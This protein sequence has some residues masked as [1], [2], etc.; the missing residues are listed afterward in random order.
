MVKETVKNYPNVRVSPETFKILGYLK[1]ERGSSYDTVIRDMLSEFA[2]VLVEMVSSMHDQNTGYSD[3][4]EKMDRYN[5][6]LGAKR[7]YAEHWL[8]VKHRQEEERENNR[9]SSEVRSTVYKEGD[10][11]SPKV[12]K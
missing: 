12:K 6:L 11:P 5:T 9:I 8:N 1:K 4:M 2:P 10:I 3:D 7:A